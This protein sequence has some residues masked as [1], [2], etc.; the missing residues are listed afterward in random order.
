MESAE[1]ARKRYE[2][3]NKRI[4][5]LA[6]AERRKM[7]VDENDPFAMT[8]KMIQEMESAGPAWTGSELLRQMLEFN[9]KM[10]ESLEADRKRKRYRSPAEGMTKSELW[11]CTTGEWLTDEEVQAKIDAIHAELGDYS[12]LGLTEEQMRAKIDAI[13]EQLGE[14][15]TL[16]KYWEVLSGE[17]LTDEQ[18]EAK[19]KASYQLPKKPAS[20][21]NAGR[22]EPTIKKG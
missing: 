12:A 6:R 19:I 5:E 3:A 11:A 4:E 7:G 20:L 13:N 15:P 22:A 18:V 10:K 16:S 9:R 2:E 14:H 8:D 21:A 17:K 1:E